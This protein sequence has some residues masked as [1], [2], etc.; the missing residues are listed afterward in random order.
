M[1]VAA[2]LENTTTQDRLDRGTTATAGRSGYDLIVVGTG[3]GGATVARDMALRGRKVLILEW[4]AGGPVRG[5]VGQALTELMVPGKCLL[6]TPQGLG[7]VRGVATG[8]SSLFYYACAWP[9]PLALFRR[10]GVDLSVDAA[11]A[12][13]ELPIAPLADAMMTPM[14]RRLLN[15]ARDVGL[16]WA[17]LDK[18]MYQ[19]RWTPEHRFGYYGDVNGV[20]WSARMFVDEAVA[21]GAV[22]LSR[23]RVTRVLSESGVATAVEF[24]QDGQTRRASAERI[25]LAAGGIGSPLILRASGLR[26]AGHDFFFDPLITVC[27]TMKDV[28]L[29]HNEIPMSAGVHLEGDGI[30]LTD[31]P[32]PPL[33]HTLF[34]AQM[35]R[36]HKLFAHRSTARIMVKWKDALGGRLTDRGGVCKTLTAADKRMAQHGFEIA[37]RVLKA[38]G[39]TAIYRTAHLAAHPGGT[40]KIGHLVD[41]NLKSPIDRLFV[42]DCSVIPEAWGLPPSLT[43]VTLGKRLARHLAAE[44]TPVELPAVAAA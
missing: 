36:V 44:P 18:N 21:H 8:G 28:R 19:E 26:E 43:L 27:G 31:L 4:G 38:A 33:M 5:T 35:G 34:T 15:S 22:L 17:K 24:V 20:K 9:V 1:K 13:A 23:A 42:C 6:F 16:P 29:Q 3:P 11:A 12:R 41:T 30:M 2:G 14:A 7:L 32:F 10:H 40:A 37:Q 39:A 25:V